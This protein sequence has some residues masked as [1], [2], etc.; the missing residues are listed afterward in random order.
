MKSA[1][2]VSLMYDFLLHCN[3]IGCNKWSTND[4]ILSVGP[5]Q[6]EI[7]GLPTSF[8]LWILFKV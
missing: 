2:V 8:G 7:I 5:S 1:I 4:N 3:T 6:P